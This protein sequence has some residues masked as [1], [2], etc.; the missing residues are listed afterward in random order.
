MNTIFLSGKITGDPNYRKKFAAAEKAFTA[1]G[2]AVVSPAHLPPEGLEYDAYMRISMAMQAE[3]ETT[4]FLPD[5]MES[6]GSKREYGEAKALGK[7]IMFYADWRTIREDETRE[8]IRNAM[9]GE[10]WAHQMDVAAR[11]AMEE[12][13]RL[14]DRLGMDIR[15]EIFRMQAEGMAATLARAA[16]EA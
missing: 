14:A 13:A 16:M 9:G 15:A 12:A 11:D 8:A 7:E 4:C 3:C 5:W 6:N 1:A 10:K 2:Y